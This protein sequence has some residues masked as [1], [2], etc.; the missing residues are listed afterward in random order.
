MEK[1][2]WIRDLV[3]AEQKMEESGVIDFSAGFDANKTLKIETVD[4]IRDLKTYFV[5]SSA[6]FNQMKTTNAGQIK[7][8]GIA[9]TI[10]D[11]MLFRNGFKL[12]F[13]IKAPGKI[14]ISFNHIGRSFVPGQIIEASKKPSATVQEDFLIAE[15]AAFE[16][17][18]WKYKDQEIKNVDFLIRYYMTLFIRESL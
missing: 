18:I 11:F 7:I 17:L 5:E 12:I 16:E 8:Y 14:S 2:E 1:L 10:A 9:K 15:W 6:A 13:S 3:T 4:Y